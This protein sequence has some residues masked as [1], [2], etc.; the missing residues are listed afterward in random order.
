MTVVIRELKSREDLKKFV[1]FPNKLYQGNKFYVPS[2]F[3][4]DLNTLDQ[5]KNP[6]FQDCS[7]RYWI[8]YK[9]RKIAGRVCAILNNPHLEKWG[10]KYLRF[11]WLDFIDDHE[12]SQALISEVEDW[13]RE[14]GMEA[15][16][17]P[18]G[19]TD[20]DREGML[21]EGFDELATL[22]TFYNYPYYR[23]HLESMGYVKD[24]DWIE[25]ELT[26]PDKQNEKITRAAEIVA[27]RN[28]LKLLTLKNKRELLPYAEELFHLLVDEYTHLYGTNPLN[29]QQITAYIKQY[30]GIVHP[31]FIPMVID[32]Q[33]KLIAFGIAIPS[34]SLALQRSR[35]KLFP[36]GWWFILR[37]LKKND[38]A[39]LML[40][41]VKKEYQGTGVNAILM[42]KITKVFLDR[43]IKKV[44]SNPELENNANV[45]SLWK[46][47]EKRQ[48]K[49]RRIFI[50]KLTLD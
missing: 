43:G 38:R 50:K 47:Y 39:D 17:G 20:L 48:H 11:S 29:E 18:L 33:G 9:N 2:L 34:L 35:G 6:A 30:F 14:L 10:Q 15:V 21:V 36:F 24:I 16:H 5:K 27:K 19:F 31:D 42:D 44:E 28:N 4:D 32:S 22:A 37:A 45:Q 49:R 40:I 1:Q 8:A 7:A 13:A 41:A 26:V 23:T 46:M 12:V 3:S 25:F